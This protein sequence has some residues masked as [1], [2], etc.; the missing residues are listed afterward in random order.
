MGLL[1]F[2]DLNSNHFMFLPVQQYREMGS[3]TVW[4]I[5]L[6]FATCI[7]YVVTIVVNGTVFYMGEL[8]NVI[9]GNHGS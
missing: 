3:H 9:G 4:K 5:A 7:L 2:L 1:V 8:Y 6:I